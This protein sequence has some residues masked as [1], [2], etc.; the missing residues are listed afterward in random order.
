MAGIARK[1]KA[2]Y[3]GYAHA[4]IQASTVNVAYGLI[5]GQ[6]NLWEWVDSMRQ[7]GY[8][9]QFETREDK[10][11]ATCILRQVDKQA[12]DAGLWMFTHA[13]NTIETLVLTWYKFEIALGGKPLVKTESSEKSIYS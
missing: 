12:V 2:K 10:R 6:V 3:A 8:E 1:D 4:E 11:A 9:F 7:R 13:P 5:D